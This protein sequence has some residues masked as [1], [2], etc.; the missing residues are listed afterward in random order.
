MNPRL[1]SQ[2][3]NPQKVIVDKVEGPAA[4]RIMEMGITPGTEL[5]V[6]RSA[7]F[8]FPIEVKVRGHLLTLREPEASSVFLN[9]PAEATN[10]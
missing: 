9:E 10:Q 3:K 7:P 2:I 4:V 1:L 5:E 8:E 6:I